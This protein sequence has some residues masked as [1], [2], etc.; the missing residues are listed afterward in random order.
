MK[1]ILIAAAALLA[2]ACQPMP[3]ND[4]KTDLAEAP[5]VVQTSSVQSVAGSEDAAACAAAGGK[6][7]PQG[8]MQSVRCVITYADAGQRCTDGDDCAGD[9]R[10]EDMANAP[11]AGTNAV[12]QCQASSSR[13][14]CYTTVENGKAE[15]TICV[16]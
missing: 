12:G 15:A 2:A 7:L 10:V 6:M 1:R 16:D 11:A 5:P 4:G 3:A 13:F 14:G 8:R 9:C